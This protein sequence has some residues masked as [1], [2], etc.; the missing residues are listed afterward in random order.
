MSKKIIKLL[1]V[2]CFV[3]IAGSLMSCNMFN[4]EKKKD[5]SEENGPEIPGLTV[6]GGKY[7]FSEEEKLIVLLPEEEAVEYTI[8]GKFDGQIKN[9]VKNT[10]IV[11]D[12]V[13]LSNSEGKAAI[14]STE[15]CEISAKAESVNKI[16]SNNEA[17]AILCEKGIEFGGS[18]ETEIEGSVKHGVKGSKIEFKGSGVYKIKGT[19]DGSAVNCNTFNIKEEKTVTLYL[20]DSKNGIK[21]DDNITI[22]SGTLYLSKLNYGFS[23]DTSADDPEVEHFVTLANC[24]IHTSSIK[25]ALYK[26]EENGYTATDVEFIEE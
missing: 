17:A 11:L 10:K 16:T 15:K 9:D 22:L 18:G 14:Y 25:K 19:T 5:V 3:G 26:T 24:T 1:S 6:T 2:I 23:T 8:S 4:S 20:S 12:N 13:E 7:S 21:A